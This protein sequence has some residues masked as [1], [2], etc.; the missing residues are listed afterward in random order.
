M[1]T[2]LHNSSCRTILSLSPSRSPIN[3]LKSAELPTENVRSPLLPT[4]YQPAPLHYYMPTSLHNS[5][6][7]TILS[8]S[9]SRSPINTLK[10]AELPTE[11]VR[12]PL[13]PT[14]YQPAPLHYYMPTSLHNSSCRT[15]LSLSPSRSPI[16]TLKSAELPTENVRSPLLPTPYQ[17]A[18]LHYYMPTSLH[19]SSCRTIL[20][21]SPSRSPINTLKSAELPT[22]N[23]RSPLLPTPYQPA[24]LHYY[25]PTSLH[26][27]SC[28][29][30]LSLPLARFAHSGESDASHQAL[31]TITVQCSTHCYKLVDR[32]TTHRPRRQLR[33]H[34]NLANL[35]SIPTLPPTPRRHSTRM[36]FRYINARNLKN[37]SSYFFDHISRHNPDVV[38]IHETWLTTKD[39][40]A[41]AECTPPGY[42]L[43]DQVRQTQRRGGGVALLFRSQFAAKRNPST[44]HSS[45][46]SADWTLRT[47]NSRIRIIVIYRP[48]SSANHLVSISTFISEFSSLLE[49][50]VICSEPLIVTGDF[51][52]HMDIQEES[53]QF[54]ELLETFSLVQHVRQPTHEKGHTIDLIITRSSDQIVS[55]DPVSDELFSDHFSISCS[56]SLLKPDL[57]VKEVTIRPKTIDLQSFLDDI[58]SSDLCN[59]Q[60]D[61]PE[62]LLD[63]YNTTLKS[64][65][66]KH[67]PPKKKT[68]TTRCVVPWF[69]KDIKQSNQV[70]RKSERKW[71]LSRHLDDL[72][73]YHR[74]RNQ[75]TS[76]M[77]RER[78]HFY[79]HWV[80]ENS[81]D[82]R[83]F[84]QKATKLLGLKC[85]M[86]TPSSTL[87]TPH[88]FADFFTI[89]MD[90][91]VSKIDSLHPSQPPYNYDINRLTTPSFTDFRELS[92]QDIVSMVKSAPCKTCEADPI[93]TTLLK[94]SIEILGPTLRKLINSSITTGV[95]YPS[96]KRAIIRPKLKR[97]NLE[98]TLAN[99]RPLSNLSF[100]S[101]LSEKATVNQ[102][103]DYLNTQDLL[104]SMQ[105]AYRRHHS[106]ETALLK[107]K[108]DLLLNMNRQHVTLLV[109]LDLSSAFDT[110]DHE[111]LLN[112]LESLFG[113]SETALSWFK[114]YLSD[115]KQYVSIDGVSSSDYELKYG[116]P[117]GSCLGPL[118]FTLYT[119][120][121]FKLIKEHLPNIHCYADDTQL[122]LSFKPESQTSER[123]ALGEMEACVSDIRD[124]FLANKLLINESKTEFQIIGTRQQLSKITLDGISIGNSEVAP[125]EAVKDLGV[126]LDNTLSMSKHVTKLASSCYFFLYNLRRIRK[127]LSKNACETLINALVVSRLDYCNSLFY[128]HPAKL[129]SQLQRVQNS[130]ARLIHQSTRYSPSSPLLQDL[131][132][133]PIKYRCI[134][135]IL[136]ITFKAIHGH[137]P[138]YIQDLVKVK[139][140]SRTLRSSTATS[141]D[142]PSIKSSNNLGERSFYIAAPTEWNRLPANIRNSP[143]LDVFKK[144]LKTHL[145]T[146]AFDT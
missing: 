32:T 101:K 60:P 10:S 36:S 49:S 73:D 145:F 7:R 12:S 104:P 2:S 106:T 11:N 43:L 39:D 56:L 107:V 140:H 51:N 6:C 121:L 128:G 115:R 27:S 129:L 82:K 38:A 90:D 17:P 44:H 34:C 26:N 146:K 5:S 135:K 46:E 74:K 100:I 21:L 131:H 97:Q 116:V 64:I 20:S 89:K 78:R 141:L 77:N 136:L 86:P 24:P 16:N 47:N 23:V 66:D 142:Y 130:A 28:R 71:R 79:S 127:Y 15:I 69:N 99:H 31:S 126:W 81:E 139:H 37:K 94:S 22:E 52:I 137:A 50:V 95:V 65:Y 13:L 92:D 134:F 98:P 59:R 8:L 91:I 93:P 9:P 117:Q 18:P 35:I 112:R 87:N 133:L 110:V 102:L 76:L 111:I 3:T 29:T 120:P 124:W 55:S 105:S 96:W 119:S 118:L 4:P 58:A 125:S 63:L 88:E 70:K 30:I 84:F 1:P 61:D 109:F 132:W 83:L 75:A 122:Y 45:F 113:I 48:P 40:A 67:A 108:N 33:S 123:S 14:P 57:E 85:G 143:S 53:T 25:M 62:A 80:S 68:I 41:R 72:A 19:N 42:T 103:L 138:S 114:S 54:T 144:R